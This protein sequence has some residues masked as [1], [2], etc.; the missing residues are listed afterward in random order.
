MKLPREGM[1]KYLWLLLTCSLFLINSVFAQTTPTTLPNPIINWNLNGPV[2][3][4]LKLGNS[5]G[6]QYTLTNY[7]ATSGP[8]KQNDADGSLVFNGSNQ[9]ASFSPYNLGA[10]DFTIAVRVKASNL[11]GTRPIFMQEQSGPASCPHLKFFLE[12]GVPRLYVCDNQYA[13]FVFGKT[14]LQANTWYD[15]VATRKNGL[16]KLYI[17]GV[18]DSSS[19][20]T[21]GN[22]FIPN[23]TSTSYLGY[24]YNSTYPGAKAYWAGSIDAVKVYNSEIPATSLSQIFTLTTPVPVPAPNT[25]PTLTLIG[26]STLTIT[27]GTPYTDAGATAFDA[28]DGNLTS[29]VVMIQGVSNPGPGSYWI[30]YKVT[31]SGGL[32]VQ[33]NRT[34]NV[35][36]KPVAPAVP[37]NTAPTISLLGSTTISLTQGATFADPGATATDKEE[38]NVSSKIV[39]TGS[40]NT[41]VVGTTTLTYKITDIGNLSAQVT[42]TVIVNPK[43]N[44]APTI[45]LNGLQTVTLVQGDIYSEQ[46]ATA[47]DTEDGTI[48]SKIVITGFINTANVGTTTLVYKITDLGNLSSEVVRTVVINPKDPCKLTGPTPNDGSIYTDLPAGVAT[49]P[50]GGYVKYCNRLYTYGN[51]QQ[52][53]K[54][55]YMGPY[56][57]MKWKYNIGDSS[58]TFIDPKPV[59]LTYNNPSGFESFSIPYQQNLTFRLPVDGQFYV[60]VGDVMRQQ[61][62]FRD[63]FVLKSFDFNKFGSDYLDVELAKKGLKMSDQI[64]FN[65]PLKDQKMK[66]VNDLGIPTAFMSYGCGFYMLGV[67]GGPGWIAQTG[68]KAFYKET[69]LDPDVLIGSAPS[70]YIGDVSSVSG[71]L[72]WTSGTLSISEMKEIFK[73]EKPRLP[74]QSYVQTI[75]PNNPHAAIVTGSLQGQI[76][77][78]PPS[79]EQS[80]MNAAIANGIP[81]TKELMDQ[82]MGI[83]NAAGVL[84]AGLANGSITQNPLFSTSTKINTALVAPTGFP[85]HSSWA[86]KPGPEISGNTNF[87]EWKKDDKAT[88]YQIVLINITNATTTILAEVTNVNNYTF[89]NLVAGNKYAYVVKSCNAYDCGFLSEVRYFQTKLPV[90]IPTP[91]ST[92]STTLTPTTLPSSVSTNS[93]TTNTELLKNFKECNAAVCYSMSGN[94]KT[95]EYLKYFQEGVVDTFYADYG[96]EAAGFF[97]G[98]GLELVTKKIAEIVAASKYAK[99]TTIFAGLSGVPGI[100]IIVIGGTGIF[101]A[102]SNYDEVGQCSVQGP[103][104]DKNI[105]DYRPSAYYCGKLAVKTTFVLAGAVGGSYAPTEFLVNKYFTTKVIK[106]KLGFVP[107]DVMANFLANNELIL[108]TKEHADSLAEVYKTKSLTDFLDLANDYSVRAL[109]RTNKTLW[110]KGITVEAM[111]TQLAKTDSDFKKEI[112][113]KFGLTLDELNQYDMVEQLQVNLPGGGYVKLDNAWVKKLPTGEYELLANETKLSTLSTYTDRQKQFKE[114]L[115]SGI[116]NF[117]TR[118]TDPKITKYIPQNSKVVVKSY[119]LT[120]GDGTHDI[121]SQYI[122]VP[123]YPPK[124]PIAY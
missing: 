82:Y 47:T 37:I 56:E 28:E 5:S 115:N 49:P 27:Q 35:T 57:E 124:L 92:P 8:G 41:S 80:L 31:D 12:G 59:L 48:T 78:T 40:V 105:L 52:R 58:I 118:T 61:I 93:T 123:I 102:T 33:V 42:R 23:I 67:N 84:A 113:K 95:D 107:D 62:Y 65:D 13:Q 87:V 2:S 1:F 51:G 66:V 20:Y 22:K 4:V 104:Y 109:Y 89:T 29:K 91:T 106:S 63:G 103:Y 122:I 45:K 32:S 50:Y 21:T 90:V 75:A 60:P 120:A 72:G 85:S 70:Y 96:I 55:N 88:S 83:S 43:P 25:P 39:K 94:V 121:Y 73:A 112:A 9:Y 77:P 36:P 6:S 99:F 7:G 68:K 54:L 11:S 46:G 71:S 100:N 26:P 34:L 110:E 18:L 116:T 53:S 16:Y 76:G 24:Q 101:I 69:N 10:S 108:F 117:S 86:T 81:V 111:I 3:G 17:N 97:V 19:N 74:P 98:M 38:G 114:D 30:S 119:L 64:C 15:I 44:T 79:L 14:T